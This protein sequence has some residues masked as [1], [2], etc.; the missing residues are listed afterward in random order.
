M[1]AELYLSIACPE[2][3]GEMLVNKD[4]VYCVNRQ[5]KS[6]ER[7]FKR[8]VIEVELEDASLPI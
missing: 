6:Y 3:T 2:C 5:C 7:V 1:K 4:A 8:P